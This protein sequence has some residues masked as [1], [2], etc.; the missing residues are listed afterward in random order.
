[1]TKIKT[2]S[3]NK[4]QK[5]TVFENL[6]LFLSIAMLTLRLTNTESVSLAA[7]TSQ[8]VASAASFSLIFSCVF[9]AVFLLW[10]SV[11]LFSRGFEYRISQL[12]FP[13]L[14]FILICAVS[15]FF[16][17]DKRAAISQSITLIAPI[18]AAVVLVQLIKTPAAIRI[19]LAVIVA[20]LA[21][22]LAQ[23]M[24][25][26][27]VSNPMTITQYEQNPDSILQTLSVKKDSFNHMLL[28]HRIYS[29]DVRGFF[30]T[31]NSAGSFAF[32]AIGALAFFIFNQEQ[33][34]SSLKKLL[35]FAFIIAFIIFFILL[36]SK[37]VFLALAGGVFLYAV[38]L[39]AGKI[40]A[41]NRANVLLACLAFFLLAVLVLTSYG[42]KHSTLPGGPSSLVRWQ[43]WHCAA[44]MIKDNPL[45]GVGPGN[46]AV[47][48][49]QYKAPAALETVADPHNFIL[50]TLA[51][52]GPFGA[53]S[54]LVML[55][56]PQV[57]LI[58]KQPVELNLPRNDTDSAPFNR[59]YTIAL[60]IILLIARPMIFKLPYSPILEVR[61]YL[62]F[63]MYVI[64]A[65]V[66]LVTFRLA[67]SLSPSSVIK[68]VNL[69]WA[70]VFCAL[71]TFLIH[72]LIEFA[73]FEPP[74]STAFW[75]L[76]AALLAALYNNRP[77]AGFRTTSVPRTLAIA[78]SIFSAIIF[79]LI[80]RYAVIPPVASR[81]LNEKA[82]NIFA[83]DADLANKY[84]SDAAKADPL[85]AS[86]LLLIARQNLAFFENSS[87]KN[88][89]LLLDAEKAMLSAAKRNPA[90]YKPYE[91]LVNAR[92][93]YAH[94]FPLQSSHYLNLALDAAKK[95]VKRY[96]NLARLRL[97]LAKIAEL[98]EIYPLALENYAKAVQI[99]DAYRLQFKKM[100]PN[101][102][103]FSRLGENNY[104]VA[105]QKIRVLQ[106]P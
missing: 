27:F 56:T 102:K 3:E 30:T 36:N 71:A 39:L 31:S 81:N 57:L 67:L 34:N 10:F 92:L 40:I 59:N 83:Q 48:Y 50:S 33:K 18:S 19:I 16:A 69:A 47:N 2:Q 104:Q 1:M 54:L 70:A 93:L 99:E 60:A 55:V 76:A 68:R 100:Y 52:L 103:M 8:I 106:N 101:R 38:W 95:A 90:S 66:F 44:K 37:G 45:I 29:K 74:I 96:P 11:K 97:N 26:K 6:L 98:L 53:A 12:E 23:A 17:S 46:F 7:S 22:N 80:I 72:N 75:F 62:Y 43:Y 35:P 9:M 4:T 85:D 25:Q 42:L 15:T 13:F 94:N 41:K 28:E 88:S 79:V 20:A 5:L 14:V 49:T 84:F 61:I 91:L 32:L 105:K 24:E 21:V 64:P 63:I 73:I 51:Q 77:N 87:R 89:Q 78:S 86:P 82:K 65:A 58:R